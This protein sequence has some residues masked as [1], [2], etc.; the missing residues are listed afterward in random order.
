MDYRAVELSES[1]ASD[2]EGLN[3]NSPQ[4]SLFH[5]LKW[6]RLLEESFRKYA[7][8]RYFLIYQDH[9]PVALCPFFERRSW[10]FKNLASLPDSGLNPWNH[11]VMHEQGCAPDEC[12]E[13]FE[14]IAKSKNMAYVAFGIL[15]EQRSAIARFGVPVYSADGSMVLDLSENPPDQIWK[16]TFHHRHSPRQ[17]I[18]HFERDGFK[19]DCLAS[20]ESL[21]LFYPYYAANLKRIGGRSYPLSYFEKLLANFSERSPDNVMLIILHKDRCV[22]GGLLALFWDARKTLYLRYFSLNRSLPSRYTPV[23]PLYWHA[24]KEAFRMGC[25]VVDFGVTPADPSDV[26]HKTKA[27]FGCH[28]LP[29]FRAVLPTSRLFKLLHRGYSFS[30]RHGFVMKGL[31]PE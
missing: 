24:I 15:E 11:V 20:R 28:Y 23:Y 5:T 21:D 10:G 13:I 12:L 25:R 22:A 27:E 6:K 3:E 18:R 26:H 19:L 30:A 14:D 4:G 1:N 9:R 29:K 31:A 7:T 8:T 17:K 2:W 16:H